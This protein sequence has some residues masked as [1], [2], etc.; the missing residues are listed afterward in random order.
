MSSAQKPID[1]VEFRKEYSIPASDARGIIKDLGLQ[2]IRDGMNQYIVGS[3]QY[4]VDNEYLLKH[5]IIEWRTTMDITNTLMGN[6]MEFVVVGDK[7]EGLVGVSNISESEVKPKMSSQKMPPNKDTGSFLIKSEKQLTQIAPPK[8]QDITVHTTEVN[9]GAIQPDA[10][11]ALL[12]ALGQV[13]QPDVLQ[14][15]RQLLE[16]SQQSFRLTTEQL[17]ALLGLSKQTVQSKKSGFIRLG[18]QYEKVKEGSS[19][20]WKVL[21]VK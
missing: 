10:L 8:P 13:Q 12:T 3:N 11:T 1:F 6:F 19:T 21:Q 2:V 14:A 16:A 7:I 4:G 17:S 5:A 9:A 18:F 15:Q 20:L